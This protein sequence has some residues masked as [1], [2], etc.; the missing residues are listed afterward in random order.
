MDRYTDWDLLPWG[1][2]VQQ[3]SQILG[4]SRAGAYSLAHTEGFPCILV[5]KRMI[6][7]KDRLLRWVEEKL[8]RK[9]GV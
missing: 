6:V 7:P 2:S 3:V 8:E 9:N 5:G 4:I 1:L